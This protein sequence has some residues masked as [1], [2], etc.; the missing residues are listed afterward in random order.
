MLRVGIIGMGFM[1][2]THLRGWGKTPAQ[3]MGT[4]SLED[5]S[6]ARYAAQNTTK[7]YQSIDALIEDVDVVDICTPTNTHHE[8][9]LRAAAAGKHVLCEK[10][11]ALTLQQAREMLEACQKA[12]VK[13]L[14]AHVVRFFPEYALAKSNVDSG[15]IGRIAVIRLTRASFKPGTD[16]SWF[17]DYE[18]SGGMIMDLMIHDFDFARWVGGDVET[19]FAKN[20]R[21]RYP[22]AD[23]DYSHVILKHKNG[24]LSHVEGGWVYPKPLFRTSLEI[25]GDAG[26]IEHPVGSSAPLGI[27]LKEDESG[28]KPEIAVPR[29]PVAEDPYTTEIKHFYNVFTDD[30]V[31]PRITAEDGFEALKIARAAIE[32]AKTGRRI[33]LEEVH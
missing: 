14:V 25:A 3:I 13:L 7:A 32:S 33:L 21:N 12:G 27:Y 4:Y 23:G 29:S 31:T 18:K 20:I 2:V 28:G 11:L 9:V 8:L 26:L 5:A 16:D 24:A 10:P 22:D 30:T 17:H 15:S 6:T 19:V 1:G